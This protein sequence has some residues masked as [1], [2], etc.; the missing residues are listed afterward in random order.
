[1]KVIVG[2][3]GR[4]HSYRLASALKRENYLFK[5]ITTIYNYS[6]SKLIKFIRPLLSS[7]NKNRANNRKNTDLDDND[8]IL[9]CE[10]GGMIEALLARID[11]TR[12]FYCILQRFNADRFGKKAAK[13]AI[14]EQVD[15]LV[16][17]DGNAL[18]A[19][20]YIKN[21]NSSIKCVMDVSSTNREFKRKIFEEEIKNSGHNDLYKENRYLW[22]DKILNRYIEEIA[23]T[24]YYIVPSQFVLNSLTSCG[25]NTDKI[26]IIPYG[27]NV[28]VISGIRKKSSGALKLLF[29]GNVN[30]NKGISYIIKAVKTFDPK[31]VI[32]TIVGAYNDKDWFV[33]EGKKASNINFVGRIPFAQVKSYYEQ[34]EVFVIDSFSEGMA[35]VGI[36]AMSCSIP[37]ICSTNTGISELICDGKEGFIISPGNEEEL[38]KK[39]SWFIEHRDYIPEMGRNAKSTASKYTWSEY[40][41][42]IKCLFTKLQQSDKGKFDNGGK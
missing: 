41:R 34:A 11:K 9:Y 26:H 37:I 21:H 6:R 38:R 24:D 17:Y 30:Y 25:V 12:F 3:P 33:K 20:N 27:A 2:H 28:E 4:Q 36:E 32:L 16:M 10:F 40:E 8:I 13:Y 31:T 23:L 15:Y 18:S 1:M 5:Y 35:Q 14:R 39:I 7:D 19:F 22:N 42:K 29:V